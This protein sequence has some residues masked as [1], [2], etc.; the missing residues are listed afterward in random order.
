MSTPLTL[1]LKSSYISLFFYLYF[2][3]Y[4]AMRVAIEYIN[5]LDEQKILQL[6]VNHYNAVVSHEIIYVQT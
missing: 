3:M 6:K 1:T 2:I 4:F 5:F